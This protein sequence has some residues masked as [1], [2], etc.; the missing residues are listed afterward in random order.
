MKL[1]QAH[2]S[3]LQPQSLRTNL[4]SLTR[5]LLVGA[6]AAASL[7]SC[8]QDREDISRVQPNYTKK[9]ELLGREYYLRSTVVQT[10]FGVGSTF[11]GA[12]SKMVRGVF[13]VQQNAL[14][15]YR[16]YEFMEG[17]EAYA[18]KS[19]VDIPL[20]D[21]NGKVI[22][23]AVPEDYQQISCNV[24]GKGEECG[25]ASRC[26][27]KWR[28]DKWPEEENWHGNCVRLG[29]KYVYR[30][31]PVLGYPILSHFDIVRG[32]ST[33][34]GEE[35]N[36]LSENT[37]DRKWFDR[38]YMR[39]A[40][41]GQSVVSYDHDVLFDTAAAGG[42][43]VIYEGENAPGGEQFEKGETKLNDT[44][45][46]QWFH[47]I[48]KVVAAP[49]STYL[50]GF[51]QIPICFFYPWYAGGVYDCNSEELK[52]RYSFLEVPKYSKEPERAY[53]A[54][55]SSDVEMEKFGYFRTERP[56]FD[57]QFGNT[58]NG[59]IRR[60]ER[61]RI[62]DKYVKCNVN[63]KDDK[64]ADGKPKCVA[65]SKDTV[66]RGDFD[67]SKMTPVP[68]VYYINADH[69]RELVAASVEITRRWSEAFDATVTALKGKK[70]DHPMYILCENS[71]AGAQ[72]AIAK[73]MPVAEWS[74]SGKPGAKFCKE[75]DKPHLFGDLR[76]SV[77]H[78]VPN[79][80][81]VGLYGYGPSAADPITGEV[82]AASAHAYVGVMKP[83]AEAAL[84]NLE[85]LAGIKDWNDIKSAN[86]KKF[87]SYQV[88]ALTLDGPSVGKAPTSLSAV[89]AEV[90]A[91]MDGDVRERLQS[92]GL[93]LEDNGG[94]YAQGRFA[95]IKQA[96]ELNALV[97]GDDDGHTI[98]LRFKDPRVTTA[99]GP[100]TYTPDQLQAF[101]L[102]NWNHTAARQG[103]E[104]VTRAL[105]EKTIHFQDF[106]DNAILGLAD[107]Y[108]RRYDA[109]FCK[110]YAVAPGTLFTAAF[111][112]VG[113]ATCGAEGE[114]QSAGAGSGR[115]CAKA[116]DG[117]NY[118]QTC[119]TK[120]LMQKIRIAL[121]KSNGGSPLAESYR[122]LPGPLYT[123]NSDPVIRATQELGRPLA[124]SLRAKFKTEL[125]ERI[126]MG[127]QEHEVGH[128]LGLRHNFEASTDAM[129]FNKEFW[130]AKLKAGSKD[131]VANPLQQDTY[132]QAIA[133]VRE[134]QLASVMDYTSKFNGRY[135]GVGLYDR[136]AIKFG[137]GNLVEVFENFKPADLDADPDGVG[138][139]AAAAKYLETPAKSKAGV[140]M[141]QHHGN[142]DMNI[143]NRRLHWSTLPKYFKGVDNML[144]RKDVSWTE[145]KGDRCS[146]DGDCG[147]GKK[148]AAFGEDKF[149][150]DSTVV[151]VPY[152]FCSDEYNGQT[153]TCATWDEGL[154]A[155]EIARNA[156][157][158]YENYWWFYGWARDS[159]TFHPNNYAA[160]VERAMWTAT[161]QFQFWAV[162]FATNQKDGWWKKRYGVDF[163]QDING[164]LAGG[165]ATLNTFNTMAQALGRPGCGFFGWNPVKGRYE[166]YT[167]VDQAQWTDIKR[168]DEVMG[169]RPLY[170]TYS[171]DGYQSRPESGGQMYDRLSALAMLTDP[172]YPSFIATNESEDTRRY[173]VSFYNVF[174]RQ[175]TNLLASMSVEDATSYGWQVVAG[176]NSDDDKLVPRPW[177]GTEASKGR[178]LCSSLP[179]G[180]TD[181]EREGC[182]KYDVFP[183]ARPVFPSSRFRMPLQATYYGMA[184]LTKGFNRTFLD[185]SRIFL[186]GHHAQIELPSDLAKEDIATFVDPL[187]GKTYIAPKVT[188]EMINPGFLAVKLAEAELKKWTTLGKLQDNYLFSEYQFRVSLLDIMRSMHEVFEQ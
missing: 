18:Q 151:E 141:V 116:T 75:M 124:D 129:N 72:A 53:V 113:T 120:M 82:I 59:A 123:D 89:Q 105:A 136:A 22:T 140:N 163:D 52:I 5:Q 143:L 126:Y 40:W 122:V 7:A 109:E 16:T 6:V 159:E 23:H 102:A 104:N 172:T 48:A 60:V 186:K 187:S 127:T 57:I 10:S 47:Y 49:A 78:A 87:K 15:F 157:E 169:C 155:Y 100:M 76:W 12:M 117:K 108:G 8:A 20:K 180:A 96:P 33:A 37:S 2:V 146:S 46:Q 135:A 99:K 131:E 153:P 90:A 56:V 98:P 43:T 25:K 107:E 177:V 62:W 167:D 61:H 170:P 27:N 81:Q 63:P 80:I 65:A 158:D 184:V 50:E 103:R 152:R 84:Q 162:D 119:S 171:Y 112:A 71:D 145:L 54:R 168:V 132:E 28:A 39:V 130:T 68:V 58:H 88:N 69:P 156:L 150:R 115:I 38:E 79:P 1:A 121:N 147:G 19:D 51:G 13:D 29:K 183:D 138:P 21:A 125:L 55:D 92:E 95:K 144:A 179:T 175:L 32:Y 24:E 11:P 133:R 64:G 101:S 160:R 161:R 174:P 149:C 118:W 30:G 70:P 94:T 173:L 166:P 164:G 110:A 36:V 14:Y 188:N 128:T 93:P 73:G 154:D 148:C 67:Y 181:A 31:A 97:S 86:E 3:G 35:T 139:L 83:G 165:L 9:S 17:S 45:P 114:Y 85:L 182:L 142:Q 74:K 4:K 137:Y 44:E 106:A 34:T 91:M 176:K 178:Q 41:G 42:G 26:A 77:M 66:W 185:V 111:S 134:K